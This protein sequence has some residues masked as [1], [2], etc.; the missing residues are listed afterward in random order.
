ML[1]SANHLCC[2]TTLS[3]AGAASGDAAKRAA[4][5]EDASRRAAEECLCLLAV[6]RAL[7]LNLGAFEQEV[8]QEMAKDLK[9]IINKQRYL[10]VRGGMW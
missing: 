4:A 7:L 9:T 6:L 3:L 10:Q 1:A 8:M 2:A 5:N